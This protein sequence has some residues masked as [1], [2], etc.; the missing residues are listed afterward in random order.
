M[1]NYFKNMSWYTPDPDFTQSQLMGVELE[2]FNFLQSYLDKLDE[3]EETTEAATQ[4]V[5]AAQAPA[6][7][8]A[9]PVV[10][11]TILYCN[12]SDYA[13]LRTAPSRSAGAICTLGYN[14]PVTLLGTSGEFY[15]VSY[16]GTNGYVLAEFFSYNSYP[17]KNYG[18][19]STGGSSSTT[20]SDPVY[21]CCASDYAT[22]RS[23]ASRNASALARITYNEPVTYLGASGEFSYVSYNGTKGYVLTKFL[24]ESAYPD[25]N[26]DE[27]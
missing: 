24:S 18:S 16:N 3:Q 5:S 15:Y 22:L 20:S 6:V 10:Y 23:S 2:N 19:G 9:P 8:A 26:Y 4:A 21:Y 17:E 11:H 12:A 27:Y 7:S 1:R 14:T 25:K 13:T